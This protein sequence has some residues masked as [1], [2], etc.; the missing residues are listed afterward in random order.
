MASARSRRAV[1]AGADVDPEF[2]ALPERLRRAIDRAFERGIARSTAGGSKRRKVSVDQAEKLNGADQGGFV[3]DDEAGGFLDDDA[4]GFVS[5][6]DEGGFIADDTQGG[7]LPD[8]AGGFDLPEDSGGFLQDPDD[9]PDKTGTSTPNSTSNAKLPLYL[10]PSLLTSL[11]LPSDEDVLQVFRASASGWGDDEEPVRR[12]KRPGEEER[13]GGVEKKDFRAVCAALMGP[14]EGVDEG[15]DLDD[16]DQGEDAFELPTEDS[17]SSL[18]DLSDDSEFRGKGKGKGKAISSTDGRTA[19]PSRRGKKAL[20]ATLGPAKLTSR[21][22]DMVKDIWEMI[23]P[24]SKEGTRG[25]WVLGRE[26]VK[27]LVRSLGEMWTDQEVGFI[28]RHDQFQADMEQITDMVSL[29]SS[30]HEGRGLSFEDF[31]GVMLRAG[32]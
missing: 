14:D 21:Q 19:R 9:V 20:E 10:L 3:V 12:R 18:S 26:E 17:E 29:F 22:R 11:G 32:L 25:S 4:G 2:L 7:F 24:G 23:K 15:G 30:Q 31:G 13:E 27:A 28:L 5:N 8:D 16:D 6:G 1:Q